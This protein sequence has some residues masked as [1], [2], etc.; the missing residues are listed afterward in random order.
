MTYAWT[1][2]KLA[3][4]SDMIQAG[5]SL[6]QIGAAFNASRH[7]IG[8]QAE[9]LGLKSRF[10][11]THWDDIKVAELRRLFDEGY[12]ASLIGAAMGMTRNAVIGKLSRLGLTMKNGFARK[13][14]GTSKSMR[15]TRGEVLAAVPQQRKERPAADV[16]PL[17]VDLLDLQPGQCHYPYG[18]GPFTFCGCPVG[19]G[20]AYCEP[21]H[22]ITHT[23]ARMTPEEYAQHKRTYREKMIAEAA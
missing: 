3:R 4:L 14:N 5:H 7:S 22:R 12:S 11:V 17:H 10:A 21:H 15:V 16:T 18:D 8:Y 13:V 9:K 6:E 23:D 1:E 2:E 19:D 20:L